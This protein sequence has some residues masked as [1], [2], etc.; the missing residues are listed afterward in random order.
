[1]RANFSEAPKS[2]SCSALAMVVRAWAFRLAGDAVLHVH[3]DAID[4]QGSGLLDLVAVIAGHVQERASG[5]HAGLFS[6]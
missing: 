2:T 1:M 6:C 4:V 5:M 3:A